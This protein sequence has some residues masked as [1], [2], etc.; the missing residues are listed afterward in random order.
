[1]PSM[2][3]QDR[4]TKVDAWRASHPHEVGVIAGK[5]AAIQYELNS[6]PVGANP[7]EKGAWT[8]VFTFK[9]LHNQDALI[10][11][12][13]LFATY[14]DDLQVDLPPALRFSWNDDYPV[15]FR[16]LV[17]GNRSDDE[18][19]GDEDVIPQ[20]ERFA[21]D[22]GVFEMGT[23]SRDGIALTDLVVSS[24]KKLQVQA[25]L[26]GQAAPEKVPVN[27][28]VTTVAEAVQ[29]RT[30][31]GNPLDAKGQGEG[32]FDRRPRLTPGAMRD[33]REMPLARPV[34]LFNPLT[35][36]VGGPNANGCLPVANCLQPAE[37]TSGRL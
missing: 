6:L 28:Y 17:G 23:L 24:D 36:N 1:M 32:G 18:D 12:L 19:L 15:Q 16:M 20:L 5:N 34:F 8:T 7:G 13:R 11:R 3:P 9:P 37:T 21:L 30:G 35:G 2:D 26:A 14:I 33:P 31:Q 10:C 25:R 29:R 4:P 22:R 27:W